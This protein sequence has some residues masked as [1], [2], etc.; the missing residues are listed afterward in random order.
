MK[1]D[2]QE[3]RISMELL[4]LRKKLGKGISDPRELEDIK[5]RIR[6]LERELEID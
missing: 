6:V 4:A 3:Y 1:I 5:E 2:C